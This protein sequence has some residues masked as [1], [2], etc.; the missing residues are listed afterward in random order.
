MGDSIVKKSRKE[1]DLGVIVENSGKYSEQCVMSVKKANAM[2]GII[3]RNIHFKSKEVIVKLYKSLV[4]PRLEYCI[5]AWNPHL[6][7]DID[8]LER[9]QKR[10][11]KLIEGYKNIDYND[12]LEKTGLTTLENRRIRGDLIQV[13]KIVKG[14]DKLDY[15]NFFE[16]SSS[17][18][19]G[20]S[21]KLVKNRC[22]GKLRGNFFSQRVIN[23]WN[24]LDQYVVDAD[25]V[26]C[27][28][29]RID[30]FNLN[31]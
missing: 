18:T 15:S 1:R 8:M 31:S 14:F 30:R 17:I 24:N 23:S 20:H 21:Y 26:N 7:R 9:V 4:R 11:T 19:R 3:K 2:L 28:K 29:N 25:S 22:N 13:F 5:Q 6:R 27:F 12:R 16:L 10:A